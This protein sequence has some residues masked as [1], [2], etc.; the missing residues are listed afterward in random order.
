MNGANMLEQFNQ[1][2]YPYFVILMLQ[3]QFGQLCEFC[4]SLNEVL[5]E[6]T[7]IATRNPFIKGAFLSNIDKSCA[8]RF[9][10]SIIKRLKKLFENLTYSSQLVSND[11]KMPSLK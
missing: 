3:A 11:I 7:C 1:R 4:I 10:R 6:K 8:V 5:V 9:E 2:R